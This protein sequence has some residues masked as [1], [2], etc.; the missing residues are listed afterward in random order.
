MEIF[1]LM[2]NMGVGKNFIAEQWLSKYLNEMEEKNTMIMALADHFKVHAIH[3]SGLEYEKVFGIKDG[4]TRKKLQELG[5]ELGRNQFG[6]DIWIQ[7][8]F[9]WMKVYY[10][11]GVKRFIIVDGRFPNEIEFFRSKGATIIKIHASDR[12]RERLLKESNYNLQLL[13][14]IQEHPSE[15]FIRDFNQYDYI[16]DNS[17]L[18]SSFVCMD[19][20]FIVANYWSKKESENENR[21]K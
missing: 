9:T 7:V 3:F 8:L 14:T 12:N 6:D 19:V 20:R 15:K 21:M 11:R 17:K 1:M 13:K 4:E 5:T 2:G 16:L 10:E 18:N